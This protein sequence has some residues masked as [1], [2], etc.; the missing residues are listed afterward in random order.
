MK[1]NALVCLPASAACKDEPD[2][3]P[4][5]CCACGV[6][7]FDCD[8][9]NARCECGDSIIGSTAV[10]DWKPCP[11]CLGSG[12]SL[13][14]TA[15]GHR[16]CPVCCGTGLITDAAEDLAQDEF[17]AVGVAAAEYGTWPLKPERLVQSTLGSVSVLVGRWS[18]VQLAALRQALERIDELWLASSRLPRWPIRWRAAK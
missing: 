16:E 17:D 9:L 2:A 14:W 1:L 3:K 5:G 8:D 13:I 4:I 11:P 7:T 6:P 12:Q 18:E 15:T 10:Q